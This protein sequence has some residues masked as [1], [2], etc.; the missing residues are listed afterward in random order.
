MIQ[1]SVRW[2]LLLT[3]ITYWAYLGSS[4]T[5]ALTR[6]LSPPKPRLI[7][8][9]PLATGRLIIINMGFLSDHRPP[10]T[11]T[12]GSDSILAPAWHNGHCFSVRYCR[13]LLRLVRLKA[14]S[15]PW[16]ESTETGLEVTWGG[17][18]R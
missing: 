12:P 7:R 18:D 1:C 15:R 16:P 4:N 11:T 10:S 2:H 17:P 8:T 6:L 9:V 3:V 14:T 13:D 5:Y